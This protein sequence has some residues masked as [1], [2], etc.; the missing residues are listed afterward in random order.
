MTAFISVGRA[1][2]SWFSLPL[3]DL[4][5][6]SAE[7]RGKSL[8]KR[9]ILEPNFAPPSLRF[10]SFTGVWFTG[11][12]KIS[13]KKPTIPETFIWRRRG[14]Q[15]S[16]AEAFLIRVWHHGKEKQPEGYVSASFTLGEKNAAFCRCS[17]EYLLQP[18][19]RQVGNIPYL[20]FEVVLIRAC[21]V[22]TSPGHISVLFFSI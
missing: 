16:L 9:C 5:D 7:R 15:Q 6:I 19:Q 4:D 11:G 22:L 3:T 17:E 1:S 20:R 21:Y 12:G 2:N 18:S 8:P 13:V 10:V 14:D